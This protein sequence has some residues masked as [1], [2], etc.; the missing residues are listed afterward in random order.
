MGCSSEGRL[1]DLQLIDFFYKHIVR[2]ASILQLA[3]E[4]TFQAKED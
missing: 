4:I 3:S 1:S 2:I